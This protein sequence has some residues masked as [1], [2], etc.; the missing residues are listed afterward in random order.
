MS[1][2]GEPTRG[3]RKLIGA[4]LVL[5]LICLGSGAGVGTLY[6]LLRDDIEQK[7]AEVF[8]DSLGRVVEGDPGGEVVGDYPEGTPDEEKVHVSRTSSGVIYAAM[9]S[10]QGYSSLIKVL[11]SVRVPEPNTPVPDDPVIEAIT[12]VSSQETPGL[13]ENIKAV[14]RTV[15]VW[16]ALAGQKGEESRPAFQKQFDDRRLTDL[17]QGDDLG[18]IDAVTGATISS[19]AATK[20]VRKAVRKII[21]RTAEVYGG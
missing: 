15:S 12:V 7:Q 4:V 3:R 10:E 6:F 18:N 1:E 9:G 16:G 14:E 2:T 13:G 8:S 20:A 21:E 11:A 17:G 19:L 5:G